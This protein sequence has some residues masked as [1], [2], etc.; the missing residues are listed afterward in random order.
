MPF[1]PLH[2]GPGAAL[3]GIGGERFSF[4][5]FG[6]SQVLIDIEPGYRMLSGDAVLH[7]PSHTLAGAFLIAIVAT[8]IGKPI[9]EW[10]LKL[11]DFSKS[12][13][14]WSASAAGAFLGTFSHLIFDAIMHADMMPWRP[15][16]D[17]NGLLGIL[18]LPELHLLCVILGVVGGLII[19]VR[20]TKR[21]KSW[22]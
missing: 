8:V 13:I 6:G 19:L 15:L 22:L 10:A 1:T 12:Q 20:Y 3:K 7:G 18:T 21:G 11:L 4:M 5:V 14:T 16:S 17:A 9:S 2:L